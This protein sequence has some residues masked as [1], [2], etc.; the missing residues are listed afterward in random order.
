VTVVPE[1]KDGA[2]VIAAV[3]VIV[4]AETTVVRGATAGLAMIAGR[5]VTA[6][7]AGPGVKVGVTAKAATTRARHPSSRP[8]SSPATARTDRPLPLKSENNEGPA[9]DRGAFSCPDPQH[10]PDAC[11]ALPQVRLGSTLLDLCRARPMLEDM[12]EHPQFDRFQLPPASSTGR[13]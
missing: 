2:T 6:A 5:A 1:A 8:H 10:P 7:I 9:S 12:T 11:R 4:A 13:R 3:G